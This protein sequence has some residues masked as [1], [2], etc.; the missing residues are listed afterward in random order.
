MF[1]LYFAD[2]RERGKFKEVLELEVAPVLDGPFDPGEVKSVACHQNSFKVAV[3]SNSP[4][5][6][7]YDVRKG[8][9]HPLQYVYISSD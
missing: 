9:I 6:Q 7:L 1:Q 4:I 2:I 5:V 3:G 8:F